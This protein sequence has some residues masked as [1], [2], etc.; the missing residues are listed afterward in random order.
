MLIENYEEGGEIKYQ[1]VLTAEPSEIFETKIRHSPSV[2]ISNKN[3]LIQVLQ[4]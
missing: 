4:T 1:Y 3:L 2:T